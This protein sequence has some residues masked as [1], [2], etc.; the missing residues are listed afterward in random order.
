MNRA[1][2]RGHTREDIRQVREFRFERAFGT[3]RRAGE[4]MDFD[5]GFL[6]QAEHGG[7]GVFL[8]AADDQPGDDVRDAHWRVSG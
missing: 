2:E 4:Q 3:G 7:D 8:S 1:D 5:A 6:A